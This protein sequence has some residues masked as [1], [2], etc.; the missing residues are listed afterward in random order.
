MRLFCLLFIFFKKEIYKKKKHFWKPVNWTGNSYKKAKITIQ[1]FLLHPLNPIQNH[2]WWI[3]SQ[4]NLH[5]S[6]IKRR[7]SIISIQQQQQEENSETL[8]FD[9]FQFNK[10]MR[11]SYS[12]SSSSGAINIA[13]SAQKLEVD[14]RISL[15][16]YY[17]IADNI[18]RQVCSIYHMLILFRNFQFS[19]L[20]IEIRYLVL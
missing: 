6:T 20:S 19:L 12:S 16:F 9:S 5:N 11:S 15:R 10:K 14:N 8:R 4:Q 7:V 18:L 1:R 13:M 2:H 17:R 3:H